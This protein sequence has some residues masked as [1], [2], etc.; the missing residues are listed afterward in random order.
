MGAGG[1]KPEDLF[2]ELDTDGN[3]SISQDELTSALGKNSDVDSSELFAALDSDGD[4]S[5]SVEES[6]ALA[7]PPPPPP[8]GM[9]GP[10]S[11]GGDSEELFGQQDAD[12]NGSVSQD[13]LNTLFGQSNSSSGGSSTSSSDQDVYAKLVASLLKQYESSTTAYTTRVGSQL[14]TAA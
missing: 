12:G 14:S 7:P 11:A 9:G 10:R 13:E 8:G 4:G 1:G 6:A 3:G 2:G 5:L